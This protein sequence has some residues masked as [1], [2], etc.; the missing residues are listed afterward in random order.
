[1]GKE[2]KEKGDIGET[3]RDENVRRTSI[4]GGVRGRALSTYRMLRRLLGPPTTFAAG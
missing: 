3:E 1:V 2:R 4:H